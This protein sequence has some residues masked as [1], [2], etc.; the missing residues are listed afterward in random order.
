MTD[1]FTFDA[2]PYVL[3]ALSPEERQIF[4]SH[5]AECPACESAVREF[6]GLPGLLSRLPA[7][8]VASALQGDPEPPA[9]LLP[10]LQFAVRR[11][12]RSRRWRGVASGL[13]AACLAIVATGV[14]VNQVV[15]GDSGPSSGPVVAQP[16]A[17]VFQPK[18][19]VP[20]VATASLVG[21]AWG[22]EIDMKCTY[23][24]PGL[25][26]D[27][28]EYT[29]I[30]TD[31]QNVRHRVGDWGVLVGKEIQLHMS[32]GI[33]RDQIKSLQVVNPSNTPVLELNL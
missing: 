23:S 11:E 28:P 30:A 19:T 33:Q 27:D 29:L 14:V 3:G 7:D 21:K 8:E 22:T 18:T 6:A 1:Q 5:L 26:G 10:A 32:T 9:T 2:A 24:G 4:E 16:Q 20:V 25:E 15:G 17:L 31:R 12:R 13:A